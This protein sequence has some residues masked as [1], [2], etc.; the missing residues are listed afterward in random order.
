MFRR[1]RGPL[2]FRRDGLAVTMA[3]GLQRWLELRRKV[4]FTEERSVAANSLIDLRS[5]P[6]CPHLPT[7]ESKQLFDPM[8]R[9]ATKCVHG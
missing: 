1:L 8:I 6:A 9:H 3:R 5:H 4:L 2:L 7:S